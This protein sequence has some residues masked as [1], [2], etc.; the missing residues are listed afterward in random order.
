MAMESFA[1]PYPVVFY[2]GET[3]KEV[4][5]IGVHSVLTFKRFQS[6]MSQKT[7]LPVNQLSAVFVCRRTVNETD[8]KQ[9]LPINENTN[10]CIILNQHN[11]SRE[12]DAHFLISVKK[13]KKDRKGSRKKVVEEDEE[14]DDASESGVT[15]SSSLESSGG[16]SGG[17]PFAPSQAS[18]VSAASAQLT[19]QRE[20]AQRERERIALA[21]GRAA[22]SQQHSGDFKAASN[23]RRDAT[24]PNP[25]TAFPGQPTSN[26][27]T[28][29]VNSA[30]GGGSSGQPSQPGS[31]VSRVP[32]LPVPTSAGLPSSSNTPAP[33]SGASGDSSHE[34]GEEQRGG[35]S[36]QQGFGDLGASLGSAGSPGGI[37]APVSRASLAGQQYGHASVGGLVATGSPGAVRG[38][39]RFP[40]QPAVVS[41]KGIPGSGPEGS[42]SLSS[43][44]LGLG[45]LKLG[46]GLSAAGPGSH[47]SFQMMGGLGG[48][49]A[50]NGGYNHRAQGSEG[51]GHS[52]LGNGMMKSVK[53]K[54]GSLMQMQPE[55]PKSCKFC[56]FC[57]DRD[58]VPPFHWCVDDRVVTGFRGPSPAG[59][60]ARTITTKT[61]TAQA[62][63]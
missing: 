57:K 41:Q 34:L 43:G 21:A 55:T 45:G 16:L 61:Q 2:D 30:R 28:S 62:S 10:F 23:A 12:R 9:K 44:S 56:S 50:G 18:S 5:C 39:A 36:N 35:N 25:T 47:N 37:S 53:P 48:Q 14:E 6:L 32:G 24:A 51:E 52:G 17:L 4:G 15:L 1:T 8:K 42:D 49:G 58:R 38:A 63:S 3:E 26:A 46:L 7:G 33:V 59:P 11:P 29:S 31:R 19:A 13:S 54:V 22:T 60:I 40:T 20:A 27:T